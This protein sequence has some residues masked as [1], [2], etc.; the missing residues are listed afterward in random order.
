MCENNKWT[1]SKSAYARVAHYDIDADCRDNVWYLYAHAD[2]P[3]DGGFACVGFRE[4]GAIAWL[5]YSE[6]IYGPYFD[7]AMTEA[8]LREALEELGKTLLT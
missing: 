1:M 7:G 8:V 5:E 6:E 3:E 4:N 2:V